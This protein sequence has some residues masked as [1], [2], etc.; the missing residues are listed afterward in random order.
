M[1]Q[2]FMMVA[3]NGVLLSSRIKMDISGS[4]IR[5]TGTRFLKK[6]RK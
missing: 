6:D 1:L 4:A 5:I 2:N 3:S